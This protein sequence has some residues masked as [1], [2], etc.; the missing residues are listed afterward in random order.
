M[1]KTMPPIAPRIA[2]PLLAVTLGAATLAGCSR[3]HQPPPSP[4]GDEKVDAEIIRPPVADIYAPPAPRMVGEPARLL[5]PAVMKPSVPPPSV[6]T[7]A[8]PPAAPMLAYAYSIGLTMPAGAVRGTME[9][10]Q[11]A[12]EDAGPLVCQVTSAQA[13]SEGRDIAHAR[14]QIRAT[15]LWL[16][17]FREGLETDAH[18]HGGRVTA[19]STN[20]QDLTRSLVD[21]DAANKARMVLRDRLERLLAERPG[22]LADVMQLEQQISDVQGQIDSAQA[23]LEVM[24]A[25]VAMSEMTLDYAAEGVVAPRDVDTPLSR[26]GRH[27][28]WNV[29][30][31]LGVM[32]TLLSFALPLAVIVTP[33]TWLVLRH[34]RRTKRVVPA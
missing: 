8:M 29:M 7:A 24:R 5:P 27:F 26:A 3:S 13:A 12:C 23:E 11:K 18:K 20:T 28:L 34:R 30:S 4:Q 9:R 15:P 17:G 31:V 22:Q 6:T 14:L 10:H 1:S 33:V 25:R 19:S 32:L 16:K 2:M 21:T